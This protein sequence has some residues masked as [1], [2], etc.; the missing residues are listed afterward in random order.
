MLEVQVT[1]CGVTPGS[2]VTSAVSC[3][4]RP[5]SSVVDAALITTLMTPRTVTGTRPTVLVPGMLTVTWDAPRETPVSNP[6]LSIVA[7]EGVFELQATVTPGTGRPLE[8]ALILRRVELPARSDTDDGV[9]STAS[10]AADS[11][12]LSPHDVSASPQLSITARGQRRPEM[13][14]DERR[15]PAVLIEVRSEWYRRRRMDIS[16]REGLENT[17]LIERGAVASGNKATAYRIGVAKFS[18]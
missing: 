10:G 8:L 3:W 7:T 6:A 13:D 11:S 15:F 17:E 18:A 2:A 12:R 5:T 1:A 9:I 4:V 14:A 16:Q